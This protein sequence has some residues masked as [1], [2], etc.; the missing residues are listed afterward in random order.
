MRKG[1]FALRMVEV[2]GYAVVAVVYTMDMPVASGEWRMVSGGWGA[3]GATE[4]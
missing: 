1:R 2:R 3:V 4:W